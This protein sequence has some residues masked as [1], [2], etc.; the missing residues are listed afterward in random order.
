RRLGYRRL[1][2]RR[3]D[4]DVSFRLELPD[5]LRERHRPDEVPEA[6]AV[7]GVERDPH[8][9]RRR[10]RGA[11]SA[12]LRTSRAAAAAPSAVIAGGETSRS[13]SSPS[14]MDESP[15]TKPKPR[16]ASRA[17]RAAWSS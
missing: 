5:A 9:A 8:E 7:D 11:L 6:D 12:S 15:R 3:Q 16:A 1:A 10:F 13:R 4:Q 2:G 17:A 14:P